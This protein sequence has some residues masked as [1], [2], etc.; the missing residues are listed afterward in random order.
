MNPETT[1]P[2]P[3][4]GLPGVRA[5]AT[6]MRAVDRTPPGR[7][8]ADSLFRLV[9]VHDTSAGRRVPVTF[10]T[11]P[12]DSEAWRWRCETCGTSR[13]TT[14]PHTWT[15]ALAIARDV[16]GLTKAPPTS[17]PT[18]TPPRQEQHR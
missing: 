11:V 6:P 7:D 13:T 17:S 3:P 15:A 8:A 2:H 9:V 16:L 4:P 1:R 12:D 10:R 18:T 5:A 14:C